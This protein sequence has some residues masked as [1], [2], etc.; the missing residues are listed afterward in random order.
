MVLTLDFELESFSPNEISHV[1][2]PAGALRI[3]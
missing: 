3:F 1:T 2:F